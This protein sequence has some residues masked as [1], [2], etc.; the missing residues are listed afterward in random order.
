M[1]LNQTVDWDHAVILLRTQSRYLAVF[2]LSDPVSVL[3]GWRWRVSDPVSVLYGSKTFGKML[4][5]RSECTHT[6]SKLMAIFSAVQI[7]YSS[8][9]SRF[10]NLVGLFQKNITFSNVLDTYSLVRLAMIRDP[11][12]LLDWGSGIL[13][14]FRTSYDWGIG[15]L[16]QFHMSWTFLSKSTV[17]VKIDWVWTRNGLD[18]GL[19]LDWVGWW[20]MIKIKN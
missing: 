11:V 5:I 17:C 1:T 18:K 4:T 8:L 6:Y 13:Y 12:L 9:I 2:W 15:I 16:Y 3:Y 14:Q 19:W 10:R 7:N 20:L